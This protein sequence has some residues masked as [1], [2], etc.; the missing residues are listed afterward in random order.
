VFIHRHNYDYRYLEDFV[1]HVAYR[2]AYIIDELQLVIYS[3]SRNVWIM[4]IC[5]VSC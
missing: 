3:S 2:K 4:W 1:Q 5:L